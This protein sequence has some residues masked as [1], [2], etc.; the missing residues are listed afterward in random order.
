M[1][2]FLKREGAPDLAYVYQEGANEDLPAII[3]LGGFRSDMEGTKALFL[4]QKCVERDQS[5]LRFDYSGH[6][7]SGGDFKEGTISSW[8]K[9]AMDIRD[10]CLSGP[11]ILVGSSMGG[12]I[13]LLLARQGPDNLKGLIGIAAAPDFTRDIKQRFSQ[14]QHAE[15]NEKGYVLVPNDY[16]DEPYIFTKTLID[17]GEQ[18]CLLDHEFSFDFPVRL[19]QGMKDVDVPWQTAYRIKNVLGGDSDV[20]L[21][22]SADHRLSEPENLALLD[23]QVCLLSGV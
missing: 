19:I 22:E 1:V 2:Q 10:H 21:I 23:E 9:D 4:E 3:F 13:S 11:H 15:L 8:A 16:S 17:D 7:R 12:W 5:F 6:G 18:N 20:L 14:E